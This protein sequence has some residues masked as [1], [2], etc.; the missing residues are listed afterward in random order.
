MHS[1]QYQFVQFFSMYCILNRINN[2]FGGCP[3]LRGLWAELEMFMLF[4]AKYFIL[5]N[6]YEKFVPFFNN[7]KTYLRYHENLE[8]IATA[9]DKI[10]KHEIKWNQLHLLGITKDSVE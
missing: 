3:V 2:F 1:H 5:K 8:R 4:Y 10:E 6:K 9:K 7:F